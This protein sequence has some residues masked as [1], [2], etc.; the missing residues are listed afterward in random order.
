MAGSKTTLTMLRSLAL[1]GAII[2]FGLGIWTLI[3]INDIVDRGQVVFEIFRS[4]LTDD[5]P[6][7]S[8]FIAAAARGTARTGILIVFTSITALAI[9]LII[10]SNRV[11]WL[12]ISSS[13]VMLI[14]FTAAASSIAVS[15]CALSLRAFS[16][17]PYATLD[18]ADLSYFALLDPLSRAMA[19]TSAATV[20]LLVTTC[21]ASLIN[22]YKH[23]KQTKD[24]RS[25]EP[26]VSALG[27]SYGFHALHPQPRTTRNAI[28]TMYDP[29][30]AFQKG[31]GKPPNAKQVTFANEGAW[32]SRKDSRWSVSTTSQSGIEGDIMRL[33]EVKRAK[34]VV[35]VRPARPWKEAWNGGEG[36]HMI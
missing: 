19:L 3:I 17:P 29:Y 22:L 24:V 8:W 36:A 16:T 11:Y 20:I 32:M 1:I 18:S 25:F 9:L 28:P 27:M 2:V 33:L 30:K 6:L 35:L 10:T 13:L 23:R 7:W 31:P 5:A 34:R 21:I 4:R 14:E 15:G 26:T 12:R